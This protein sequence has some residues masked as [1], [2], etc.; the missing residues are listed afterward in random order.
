MLKKTLTEYLAEELE[1]EIVSSRV[2]AALIA[3]YALEN[4]RVLGTKLLQQQVFVME[5]SLTEKLVQN[6]WELLRIQYKLI[7]T[8]KGCGTGFVSKI[9]DQQWKTIRM[10]SSSALQNHN[11]VAFNHLNK[12]A[13]AKELPGFTRE[14]RRAL[15]LY[16]ENDYGNNRAKEIPGLHEEVTSWLSDEMAYPFS[17]EEVYY[18]DDCL[19]LL[20]NVTELHVGPRNELVIINPFSLSPLA[21]ISSGKKQW[22]KFG[23]KAVLLTVAELDAFC[24]SNKVPMVFLSPGTPYP[25][26]KEIFEQIWWHLK[27]LQ[28]RHGFMI[29]MYDPLQSLLGSTL[30]FDELTAG[31]NDGVYYITPV[32]LLDLK[33]EAVAVVAGPGK[34]MLRLRKKYKH[35][36]VM[37]SLPVAC[38]LYDWF[39]KGLIKK[40]EK[41]S[42]VPMERRAG[43]ARHQLINCGMFNEGY[44][45][46]QQKWFFYLE[47]ANG[48][49]PLRTNTKLAALGI[50]VIQP[51]V[52]SFGYMFKTG[53]MISIS[54]FRTEG[55]QEKEIGVLIGLVKES[56]QK[57]KH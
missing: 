45:H 38:A 33:F 36:A 39:T 19:W 11:G 16:E 54:S 55:M 7:I 2:L 52:L 56:M 47:P 51:N 14:K 43:Q 53:I 20:K 9:S 57:Y 49:L 23:R 27:A 31:Q 4:H 37:V 21:G 28:M 1:N 6:T 12:S 18:T 8:G 42:L 30:I 35:K 44:L 40:Y 3:T 24:L 41:G 13:L 17:K 46:Q 48:K 5:L 10:I 15:N 25:Y 29:L 26:E 34:E 32:S 22:R 50:K